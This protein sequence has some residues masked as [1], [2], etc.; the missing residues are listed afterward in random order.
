MKSKSNVF[1]CFKIFRS[2]SEKTG[3]HTI[4]SLR[5][6]NGGEYTSKEFE[7]YLAAAGIHHKPGH[8]ILLNS[9]VLLRGQTN[10]SIIWYNLLCW[11]ANAQSHSGRK[12]FATSSTPITCIHAKPQPAFGCLSQSWVSLPST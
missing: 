6:D 12:P 10:P 1:S 2:F 4:L 9:M 3:K 7:S 11:K 8:P 5:T